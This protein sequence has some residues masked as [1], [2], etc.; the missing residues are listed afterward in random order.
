[1]YL[2]RKRSRVRTK[3]LCRCGKSLNQRSTQTQPQ[4]RSSTLTPTRT[5]STSDP[6]TPRS[7]YKLRNRLGGIGPEAGVRVDLLLEK[8]LGANALLG[9]I[10]RG[11]AA[12]CTRVSVAKDHLRVRLLPN[13]LLVLGQERGGFLPTALREHLRGGLCLSPMLGLD[14]SCEWTAIALPGREQPAARPSQV[15]SPRSGPPTSEG[16]LLNRGGFRVP[17]SGQPTSGSYT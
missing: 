15:G 9:A 13:V 11:D 10:E 2:D 14:Q 3:T 6:R 1:M 7:A 4:T 5:T 12:L 8:A 16:S 17:R